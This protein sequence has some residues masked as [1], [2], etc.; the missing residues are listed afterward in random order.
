MALRETRGQQEALRKEVEKLQGVAKEVAELRESK[1]E[2][3]HLRSKLSE[4]MKQVTEVDAL[5]T[6]LAQAKSEAAS[7][8]TAA[9]EKTQ[10]DIRKL[11]GIRALIDKERKELQVEKDTFEMMRVQREKQSLKMIDQEE[12]RCVQKH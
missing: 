1:V 3:D 6:E 9:S 7:Q 5:R 8:D 12:S 10:S 11:E 4:L 2:I